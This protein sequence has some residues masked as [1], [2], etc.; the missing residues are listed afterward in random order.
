MVYYEGKVVESYL[1]KCQ[2][3]KAALEFIKKS[4]KLNGQPRVII[5]DKIR[6]YRAAMMIMGN[7]DRQET[8]H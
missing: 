5:T 3:R 4:M 6:S 7:A 8:G 2:N 1:S